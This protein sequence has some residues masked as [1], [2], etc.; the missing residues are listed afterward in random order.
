MSESGG[1]GGG[2]GARRRPTETAVLLRMRT[3]SVRVSA[4]TQT[5]PTRERGRLAEGLGTRLGFEANDMDDRDALGH[6]LL[7]TTDSYKVSVAWIYKEVPPLSS[8]NRYW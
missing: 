2:G 8:N 3:C 1:G 4:R 6:N 7:L 5:P